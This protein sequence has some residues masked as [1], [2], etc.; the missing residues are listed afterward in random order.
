[1]KKIIFEKYASIWIILYLIIV[2][3]M[4]IKFTITTFNDIQNVIG[5][6][7]QTNITLKENVRNNI[8][9]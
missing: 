9:N 4:L 1:M 6:D 5:N 7:I 8:T 3:F 2:F